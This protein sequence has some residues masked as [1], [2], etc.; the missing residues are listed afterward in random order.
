MVKSQSGYELSR[1]LSK[2]LLKN[3]TETQKNSTELGGK[4][5]LACKRCFLFEAVDPMCLLL[6][7]N[8]MRV[9][10][11]DSLSHSFS[12]RKPR[13]VSSIPSQIKNIN[14]QIIS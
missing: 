7:E 9:R 13:S 12:T 6:F 14:E 3:I 11:Q 8:L 5:L 2:E 4:Y 10:C 1:S